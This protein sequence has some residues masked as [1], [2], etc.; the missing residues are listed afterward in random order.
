VDP[1]FYSWKK[2][3]YVGSRD[4]DVGLSREHLKE[5]IRALERMGYSRSG[6]RFYRVFDHDRGLPVREPESRRRPL[7][8]LFYV[9]VDV[10]LDEAVKGEVFLWDPLLKF[11]LSH[12]LV[13]NRHGYRVLRAEP[14]VLMKLR[15]LGERDPEKRVKDVMDVLLVAGLADFDTRLFL[16]LSDVFRFESGT[17]RRLVGVAD[18]ELLALGLSREEIANLKTSL[19]GLV[20]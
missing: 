8:E 10:V 6:F 14:L 15:H 16:E 18:D 17:V 9:Y 20:E 1:E 3:H 12:G 19:L 2:V 4:I 7:F 5:A 11:C 13:E